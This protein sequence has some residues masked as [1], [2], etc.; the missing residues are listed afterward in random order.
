MR[1]FFLTC[2]SIA[3]V[4]FTG[5]CTGTSGSADI[6]TPAK[7]VIERQIG[8]K[9]NGI[10]FQQINPVDGK[11]TFEIL[12]GEGCFINTGI[13]HSFTCLVP[14][15]CLYHSFVFDAGIVSGLPGSV[16]DTRYIRPLLENGSAYLKFDRLP[17]N[18]PFFLDFF[19]DFMA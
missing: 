16:F 9:V 19:V 6:V 3:W 4:F 14:S 2:F 12:P 7:H 15:P 11:E 17:E 1:S 10:S 8:E 18:Q 13:L 5:A